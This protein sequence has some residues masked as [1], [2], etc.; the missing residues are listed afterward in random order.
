[1]KIS[2][3]RRARRVLNDAKKG[4]EALRELA[5]LGMAETELIDKDK[6]IMERYNKLKAFQAQQQQVQ[7]QPQQAQ[8]AQ[9]QQPQPDMPIWDKPYIYPKHP[10][11]L[12]TV[13]R[14][15]EIDPQQLLQIVLGLFKGTA[16]VVN[17]FAGSVRDTYTLQL[18]GGN[19]SKIFKIAKDL[20]LSLG[21]NVGIYRTHTPMTISIVT[22]RINT[23]KIFWS[24]HIQKTKRGT[25]EFVGGENIF[26]EIVVLD[27]AKLVHVLFSGTTGSGKSVANHS[28]I[29]TVIA[30]N[31]PA[32][33][34]FFMIDMKK[35][36]FG[37]YQ[38][39]PHL[40][41]PIVLG[42]HDKAL[43]TIKK[44]NMIM[45]QRFDEKKMYGKREEDFP[46]LL[47]I[48]DEVSDLVEK[49]AKHSKEILS[50]FRS[51]TAKGRAARVHLVLS[52]QS[53]RADMLTGVIKDNLSNFILRP[54]N[55]AV[56]NLLGCVE[57][58]TLKGMGDSLV[59][60]H[61]GY[62]RLQSPFMDATEIYNLV[63][64]IKTE[65]S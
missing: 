62:V 48:I 45:E 50:L 30:N 1:M 5:V 56:A 13:G 29:S 51:I 22:D 57:A 31:S 37:V 7:L 58:K 43:S 11:S 35:D 20:E 2:L 6:L 21:R 16:K 59:Q 34:S 65:N 17:T 53:P 25:I 10:L 36:E 64:K 14:V 15:V 32:E 63:D 33:A 41:A 4:A 46:Y 19:I 8:Q 60:T 26:G 40:L 18:G 49:S 38:G 42:D 23:S 47:L 27:L 12:P 61:Q 55:P 24:N 52:T 9:M 28:L 39:L 44:V 3:L 54:A